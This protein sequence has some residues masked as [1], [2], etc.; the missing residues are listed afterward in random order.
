MNPATE[1]FLPS[2]GVEQKTG[3]PLPALTR[4]PPLDPMI[5]GGISDLRNTR[6]HESDGRP[7]GE[8]GDLNDRSTHPGE[9]TMVSLNDLRAMFRE[10]T[11]SFSD[12]IGVL[13]RAI[14]V[15]AP[16][17]PDDRTTPLPATEQSLTS[18]LLPSSTVACRPVS[19]SGATS[20]ETSG[21]Q[22]SVLGVFPHPGLPPTS[23]P[24][25]LPPQGWTRP[26]R[27]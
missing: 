18:Q 14:F 24:P 5:P 9:T 25:L 10:I 22:S 1:T 2:T 23:V 17:V 16:S 21:E 26:W 20:S 15:K 11:A 7:I 6:E 4:P 27:I 13:E 19:M 12:R 8:I 3:H